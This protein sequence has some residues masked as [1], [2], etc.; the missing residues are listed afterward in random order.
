[1]T[2]ITTTRHKLSVSKKLFDLRYDYA[3][4]KISKEEYEKRVKE[5]KRG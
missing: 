5:L 2:K 3:H 1:M 4:G